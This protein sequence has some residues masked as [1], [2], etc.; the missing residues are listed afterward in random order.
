[1]ALLGLN[2]ELSSS[3]NLLKKKNTNNQLVKFKHGKKMLVMQLKQDDI[4]YE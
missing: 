2:N 1:M 3:F 4:Q